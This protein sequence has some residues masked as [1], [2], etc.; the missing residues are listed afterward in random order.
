MQLV[1]KRERHLILADEKET[2]F[3]KLENFCLYFFH[4][5]ELCPLLG[6][7]TYMHVVQ[8]TVLYS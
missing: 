2:K 7:H 3:P 5:L 4:V 6:L 1:Y 8:S